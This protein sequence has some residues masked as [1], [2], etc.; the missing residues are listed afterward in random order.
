MNLNHSNWTLKFPRSSRE[1]FGFQIQQERHKGD[2][3]VG[4]GAVFL[5]GLFIGLLIGGVI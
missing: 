5:A 1:A 4:V 2:L 3:V